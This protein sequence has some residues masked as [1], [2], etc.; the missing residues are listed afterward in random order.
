MTNQAK[1][2]QRLNFKS[3]LFIVLAVNEHNVVL[4]ILH[5]DSEGV[6]TH[7]R[8]EFTTLSNFALNYFGYKTK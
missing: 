6:S 8:A 2:G 7:P 1:V 5:R 3:A 4:D